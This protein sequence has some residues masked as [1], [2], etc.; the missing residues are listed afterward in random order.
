VAEVVD[1][2][3]RREKD[4]DDASSNRLAGE[5]RLG[6]LPSLGLW[7][8]VAYPELEDLGH[9]PR[10]CCPPRCHTVTGEAL[11]LHSYA[12]LILEL[13]DD[14]AADIAKLHRELQKACRIRQEYVP[15]CPNCR[16]R[17]EPVYP[18]GGGGPSYWRCTGC[19][20]TWV[21][22]AEVAR[23]ALTQPKMTLRQISSM[24]NIPL[25]TLYN[26]RNQNRFSGGPL[27]EVDHVRRAAERVGL[28][29]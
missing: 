26:W 9:S 14:F 28:S 6:V 10:E 7:V 13:H 12:Q 22:D 1:L 21:H 25:R 5:R 11:W 2:L 19:S 18:D 4:V 17:V 16:W 29:A 27:Y 23:L 3:D 8:S 20:K 24:L 15:K